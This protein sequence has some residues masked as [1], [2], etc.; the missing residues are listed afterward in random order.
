MSTRQFKYHTTHD[1][2]EATNHHHHWQNLRRPR[3]PKDRPEEQRTNKLSG[4]LYILLRDRRYVRHIR[5]H[6]ED[7]DEG[8]CY[9]TRV[10]NGADRVAAP[11][12]SEHIESVVPADVGEMRL[13]QSRSE[14]ITVV[15]ASRPWIFEIGERVL[16]A[17]EASQNGQAC[18]NY[19]TLMLNAPRKCNREMLTRLARTL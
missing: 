18:G 13:H 8:Q 10:T 4:V 7:G 11:H 9:P 16:D 19:A 1:I 6:E 17:R 14:R 15:C 12:L 2:T 3:R 5:E